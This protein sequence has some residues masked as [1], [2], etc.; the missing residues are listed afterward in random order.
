MRLPY[1][2]LLCA[3]T[4]ILC[5]CTKEP[6]WSRP[7]EK[8]LGDDTIEGDPVKIPRMSPPRLDGQLD[9]WSG[10]ATLGP[11]VDTGNGHPEVKHPIATFARAGWDDQNLYLAFVVRDRSPSSPF[12]RDD[13]DPHVWGK[14]SG[15]E[16]MLQPGDSHDN[17][18]Y[19]EIQVDVGGAVFDS[20]WDDYMSPVTGSG[21]DKIFG[22]MDWSSHVQRATT[23]RSGHFWSVEIALP[24]SSLATG[25][26][27]I[28]PKPGDV[29][30][31]NLYSFRDGQRLALG[32]SSIRGEGNFHKSSRWGRIQFQ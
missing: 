4:S 24:W 8:V 2:L 9:D 29:W 32:W 16:I 12:G 28:P 30:R 22:H 14:S 21:P 18:D 10:A 20:H 6:S 31:M 26:V 1:L 19:Y 11:F 13:V 5:A 15:V 23:V 7:S 17:R 27:A 25:R 3:C